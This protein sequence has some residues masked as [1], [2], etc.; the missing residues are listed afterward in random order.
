MIGGTFQEKAWRMDS[1][2]E[3]HIRCRKSKRS[4]GIKCRELSARIAKDS[5]GGL[6]MDNFG[7]YRSHASG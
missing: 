1:T 5:E 3:N 7:D 6:P 4:G 2:R